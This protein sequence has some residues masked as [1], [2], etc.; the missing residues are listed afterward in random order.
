MRI[1][2]KPPGNTVQEKTTKPLQKGA[3]Y[4]NRPIPSGLEERIQTPPGG[5]RV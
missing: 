5:N 4:G 3:E 2:P 1:S